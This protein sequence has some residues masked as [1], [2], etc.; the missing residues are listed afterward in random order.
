[1]SFSFTA[2]KILAKTEDVLGITSHKLKKLSKQYLNNYI[3]VVNYHSVPESTKDNFEKQV[4]NLLLNFENCDFN[5]LEAFLQGKYQFT[6]KPGIIFTFDDGFLDNYTVA[7]PI[8]KKYHATGYYMVSTGL[9]GKKLCGGG[10]PNKDYM[11]KEQLIDLIH[12]HQVIGCHTYSHH[13][14]NINDTDAILQKEI[15]TAKEELEKMLNQE[16]KIFCWCGG[17]RETYTKAASDV[18][19]QANY[20]YS[21][22]TCSYPI[23]PTTNPLQLDRINIE[24][25]WPMYLVR[26]CISG[27]MDKRLGKKR[28]EVHELL[29]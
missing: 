2:K 29:K 28:K 18:I 21:F 19:K 20:K 6:N 13:R 10:L 16:I 11:S 3:R 1:M 24:S 12:N 14:M 25:H 7:Y 5:T 9:I 23:L 17:E 27:S 15:V 26:F 8:L 4:K 22:L